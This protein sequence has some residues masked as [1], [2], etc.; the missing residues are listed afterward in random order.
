VA[1]YAMPASTIVMICNYTG[2]QA[3]ASTKNWGL[4]DYDWSNSLQEWSAATPMD[5]NERLLVQA[6]MTQEAQ[7]NSSVWIYRNSVYGEACSSGLLRAH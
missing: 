4:I 6:A 5:T 3:P 1:T 7:P 2:Y